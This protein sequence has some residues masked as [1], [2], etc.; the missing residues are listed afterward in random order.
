[1]LILETIEKLSFTQ[2]CRTDYLDKSIWTT[3]LIPEHGKISARGYDLKRGSTNR[4]KTVSNILLS[5][6]KSYD[7]WSLLLS[8]CF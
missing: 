4:T 2:C 3:H 8:L 1:M 5:Q 7:K 6:H